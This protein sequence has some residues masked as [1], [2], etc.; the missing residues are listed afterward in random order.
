ALCGNANAQCPRCL[1][2]IGLHLGRAADNRDRLGSATDTAVARQLKVPVVLLRNLRL[3]LGISSPPKRPPP[4]KLVLAPDRLAAYRN[5]TLTPEVVARQ[6]GT[7]RGA[8]VRW[9]A[10]HID[11]LEC[12]PPPDPIPAAFRDPRLSP[13]VVA[14]LYGVVPATVW[15]WRRQ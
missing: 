15:K 4:P 12:P 2:Q 6:S 10:R 11:Q 14:D 5:G 1:R 8:V 13:E 7:T 9:R 3:A